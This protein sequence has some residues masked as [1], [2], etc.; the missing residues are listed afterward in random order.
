MSSTS[1]T[2]S[3]FIEP[4]RLPPVI[5][6]SPHWSR[7]Y[8]QSCTS[9]DETLSSGRTTLES[10]SSCISRFTALFVAVSQKRRVPPCASTFFVHSEPSPWKRAKKRSEEHT[11]ELQSLRHLVCRLLLEKKKT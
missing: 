10:R 11:S 3:V 9:G 2:T 6:P 5:R 7:W 1:C 4:W 8:R